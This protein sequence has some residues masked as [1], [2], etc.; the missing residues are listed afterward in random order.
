LI[1]R[2]P[3]RLI[4]GTNNLAPIDSMSRK[5]KRAATTAKQSA[6]DSPPEA[7]APSRVAPAERP[8]P[9]AAVL[10]VVRVLLF[11]ALGIS[12]YLAW[13]SLTR[14][15]VIGCGPESDCDRVL[16]SRW[17]RWFGIPVSVFA[18]VV[19]L[20]TLWG[21]FALGS[22]STVAKRQRG[23]IAVTFG[24]I[25]ILGAGLW[26]VAL[27]F[28]SVGICPYC[29]AAHGAGVIAAL[30]LLYFA[31]R[32]DG[33]GKAVFRVAGYAAVA[34]AVLLLGQML[35]TP[36]TGRASRDFAVGSNAQTFLAAQA[37]ALAKS[38]TVST[39]TTDTALATSSS[40]PALTPATNTS[41]A[42][43]TNVPSSPPTNV[44]PVQVLT[45]G[46]KP[47]EAMRRPFKTYGGM[48]AMD[49]AE[50]PLV[51]SETNP[52]VI[53]SLFDYTCYHCRL[54]HPALTE[55]QSIFKD[56]L[57]IISLPMPLDPK[58]NHTL[59]QTAPDHSNA[60]VY[61]HLALAMFRA[62]RAKHREFDE[63]LFTGEQPPPMAQAVARAASL[64]GT[65]VLAQ[66]LRDPWVARQ[67]QF[68]VSIY[69]IAYRQQRGAMP[70]LIIGNTVAEGTYDRE[71][72]IKLLGDH[73]GLK[74]TP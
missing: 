56:R 64:I 25:L 16:Q 55:V 17:A 65:N 21:T 54:M 60:C 22:G 35:H 47:V 72:L 62:D 28:V 43:T 61:A 15:S 19:D 48:V 7:T 41:M 70:Q 49:L 38:N 13:T 46:M 27:Q 42:S 68:D 69:E 18:I 5:L 1:R 33:A 66:A 67:I 74:Q 31:V 51:G 3:I 4:R 14:G 32:P 20:L 24:A 30:V 23:W 59:I 45:P 53:V 52:Q 26:F 44:V 40:N 57:S 10:N 8:W 11:V 73:L 6:A 9:S 39:S 36:K 12:A 29:M 34:L 71:G 2:K 63:W 58:C 50:V 37:A